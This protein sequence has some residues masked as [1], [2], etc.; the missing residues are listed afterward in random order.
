MQERCTCRDH[1]RRR[2]IERRLQI[3]EAPDHGIGRHMHQRDTHAINA[4][5]MLRRVSSN[6]ARHSASPASSR[7]A[8]LISC[9]ANQA[10]RW[11][12]ASCRSPAS[13]ARPARRRYPRDW[14]R[15]ARSAAATRPTCPPRPADLAEITPIRSAIRSATSRICV[16]I[17]TVTAIALTRACSRPL[18]VPRRYRIKARERFI[19]NDQPRLMHERAGQRHLLPH[20]F[21]KSLAALVPRCAPEFQVIARSSRA[22][23][24]GETAGFAAPTGPQ[25]IRD[26]PAASACRRSSARRKPRP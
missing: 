22:V 10:N 7:H 18:D 6:D 19:Q 15:P 20:A 8:S 24:L 1:D 26:I 23:R 4:I 17:I 9:R 14:Y 16:V 11:W 2:D 12:T 3:R 21:G 5:A 25:R 13:C